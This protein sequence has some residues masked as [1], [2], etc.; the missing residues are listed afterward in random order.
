[1][2]TQK[3]AVVKRNLTTP[4]QLLRILRIHH[5]N[6][7]DHVVPYSVITEEI[8]VNK[9]YIYVLVGRLRKKNIPIITESRKGLGLV[10]EN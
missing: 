6:Y 8:G 10:E 3:G 5:S 4:Q 2:L 1:M 9:A 7:A